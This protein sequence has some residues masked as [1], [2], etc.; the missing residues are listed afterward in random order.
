MPTFADSNRARIIYG[1]EATFGVRPPNPQLKT[2]RFTTSDLAPSKQTAISAELRSDRMIADM[3][4][5]GAAAAGGTNIELSLGGTFDDLIE[6]ALCGTW[7]TG[8]SAT[9]TYG[10]VAGSKTL[11]APTGNPFANVNVGQWVYVKG[12]ANATNNG[13]H[14]VT[15][16]PDNNTLV[17]GNDTGL[18]TETGSGDERVG[19]RM[20]RNG[21]VARSFAVETAFLDVSQYMLTLGCRVGSFALNAAAGELVTGSIGWTG[22]KASRDVA[23]IQ[24]DVGGALAAPSSSSVVNATSNVGQITRNGVPFAASLQRIGFTLDNNLREQRAIGALFPVGIG[25]GR[26][27][28]TGTLVAY[29]EDGALWDDFINHAYSTVSWAFTDG[30]NNF[31]RITLP[32]ITFNTSAVTPSGVDTDVLESID[33]QAIR[34]PATGCSLQIDAFTLA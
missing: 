15:S 8:L 11:S 14:Q 30:V 22:T 34:D 29:F 27:N 25:Y 19:G 28:V 3:A 21:I 16:K 17:F 18:V 31:M 10:I 1:P 4:E 23:S 26:C 9:G 32:R 33:Y 6:A 13:W 5:V 24:A 12:F 7:S 20:V 2:L